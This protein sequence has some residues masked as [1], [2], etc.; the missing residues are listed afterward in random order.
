[1]PSEHAEARPRAAVDALDTSV[2]SSGRSGR[3]RRSRRCRGGDPRSGSA[4]GGDHHRDSERKGHP[5]RPVG[6]DRQADRTRPATRRARA[7]LLGLRR[8]RFVSHVDCR[9]VEEEARRQTGHPNRQGGVPR[10]ERF[11]GRA[12]DIQVLAR[13]AVARGERPKAGAGGGRGGARSHC[14]ESE[15]G[16][17]NV[18]ERTFVLLKPDAVQRGL[19]GE[20]LSRF[21]RRGL[22]VTALKLIRVSRSMAE[23][24]Y[25]E[26]KGKPFFE[27]LMAYVGSG[28]VVA[29]ALEG[30]GAVAVVR[31]MIGKTNAAD[32]DPGTIRGDLALTIGRNV[33]HGSDSADSAKREVALFFRPDELLSY[34]RIDET[35]L[36]E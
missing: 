16:E 26:H 11:S 14:K 1:M 29:M 32:A 10:V 18:A 5:G 35:W 36:R 9:L 8:Q 21:E 3:R 23:T 2:P 4:R 22:K 30:E 15:E 12:T 31:K 13:W 24:Y 28:P 25:S 19:I 6:P 34:A 17:V 20:I 33:I 7:T 27:P